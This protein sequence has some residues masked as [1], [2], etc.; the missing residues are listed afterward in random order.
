MGINL[1]FLCVWGGLSLYF[2]YLFLILYSSFPLYHPYFIFSPS[3]YFHYSFLIFPLFFPHY[4]PHFLSL[5]GSGGKGH[6]TQQTNTLLEWLSNAQTALQ[7]PGVIVWDSFLPLAH[8][9]LIDCMNIMGHGL[10]PAFLP[11][12]GVFDAHISWEC[13]ERLHIGTEVISIGVQMML[14]HICNPFLP[15]QYCCNR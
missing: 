12:Y 1:S 10:D 9:S 14:N 6:F 4:Y 5:S 11:Q 8:L 2:L 13:S 15:G 7:P 3:L